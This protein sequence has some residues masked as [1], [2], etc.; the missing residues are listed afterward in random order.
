MIWTKVN[1]E[2]KNLGGNGFGYGGT[3]CSPFRD[4]QISLRDKGYYLQD[5]SQYVFDNLVLFSIRVDKFL[6]GF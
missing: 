2:G 1:A 6:G 5:L 3:A 4:V